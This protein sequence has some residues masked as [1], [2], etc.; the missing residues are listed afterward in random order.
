MGERYA[1][2]ATLNIATDNDTCAGLTTA[3]SSANTVAGVAS[4]GTSIEYGTEGE[5]FEGMELDGDLAGALVAV[6]VERVQTSGGGT[7]LL[8]DATDGS[9]LTV[10]SR[11]DAGHLF[12][13]GTD[14]LASDDLVMTATG[15]VEV[16]LHVLDTSL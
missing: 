15:K 1:N 3:A 14:L 9:E 12:L 5:D 2:D 10:K 11:G 16:K 8:Q 4:S 6:I 7:L 13:T